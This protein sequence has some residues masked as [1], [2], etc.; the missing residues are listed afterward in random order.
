MRFAFFTILMFVIFKANAQKIPWRNT[1]HW[2]LYNIS[3]GN[4][5][6]YPVDTLKNFP[7]YP[8]NEDSILTFMSM[9][10]EIPSDDPPVWMGAHVA[11]YEKDRVIYKLEISQYGGFFYDE[12]TQRYFQIPPQKRDDWHAYIRACFMSLEIVHSI[13]IS[14]Y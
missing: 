3:T 6:S 2:K 9:I 12:K 11:T 4:I 7:Y 8:L 10:T 1:Q 14:T 13:K 5:F